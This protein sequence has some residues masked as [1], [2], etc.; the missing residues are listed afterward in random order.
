MRRVFRYIVLLER[1]REVASPV[2]IT[3]W[4]SQLHSRVVFV[5]WEADLVN[6]HLVGLPVV[7]IFVKDCQ[8]CL[9]PGQCER[10]CTYGLVG[11]ILGRVTN[12]GKD[13]FRNDV[14]MP[15]NRY[16]YRRIGLLERHHDSIGVRCGHVAEEAPNAVAIGG[17]ILLHGVEGKHNII[18]REWLTITPFHIRAHCER[19]LRVI[20]IPL[21]AS[22]QHGCERTTVHIHEVQRFIDQAQNA[23][24]CVGVKRIKAGLS[25]IIGLG[26]NFKD[27]LARGLIILGGAT[28][29]GYEH[30]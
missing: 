15:G 1:W 16:Q 23:C 29:T 21:V 5:L 24:I 9:V 7:G 17:G 22:R 12:R 13:V 8:V 11:E 6:F 26:G 4:Q 18:R 19:Y 27:V 2:D 20:A 10:T 28:A 3:L 30:H 25:K 14:H